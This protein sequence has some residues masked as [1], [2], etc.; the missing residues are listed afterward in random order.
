[1]FNGHRPYSLFHLFLLPLSAL[2][3]SL[4]ASCDRPACHNTTITFDKYPADTK[5]YKEELIKQ[6]EKLDKSKLTYWMV[7]YREDNTSKYLT[8]NVQGDGLCALIDLRVD[9]SVKGID[10]ILKTKGIGYIGAEL[11]DLNFEIKQ[12]SGSTEFVFRK[13]S[14]ISD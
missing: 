8:A 3:L 14:G 11:E 5:E 2:V 10:G 12:N 6:F 13:I 1:M 9:D 4:I 7:N